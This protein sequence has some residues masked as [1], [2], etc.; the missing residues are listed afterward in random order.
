MK[1]KLGKYLFVGLVIAVSCPNAY[2]TGWNDYKAELVNGYYVVRTNTPSVMIYHEEGGF[3]IPP[4]IVK[5]NVRGDIV[6]GEAE[7]SPDADMPS[8]AGFFILDTKNHK[9]QFQLDKQAWLSSLK[10]FGINKQPHLWSP[11]H[12]RSW[13][14][15]P[16]SLVGGLLLCTIFAT[17]IAWVVWRKS[18]NR[19]SLH[20][21][22]CKEP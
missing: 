2:C 9:K 14:D 12:Y 8:V 11:S 16:G 22:A 3:V 7:S 21:Q 13:G 18:V 5:L 20:N 15:W 19:D 17:V 10:D 1:L 4:K 6:F